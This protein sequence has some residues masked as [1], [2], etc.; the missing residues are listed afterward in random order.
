MR[1]NQ[2]TILGIYHVQEEYIK[3]L[4]KF[5]KKVTII[6]DSGKSRPF[7][8]IVY[9][10]NEF[11]YFAPFSSPEKDENGN[12]TEEYKKY[13]NKNNVPAYERI[14]DLKYG[15]ILINNMIPIPESELIFFKID[16]IQ[17]ENYKN[18]LKDQFIYCDDNK[19]K[20]I[21]KAFKLY[22]LVVKNKQP[23]FANISCKF[24]LLEKKCLEYQGMK[25][26]QEIAEVQ[27]IVAFT[28][29]IINEK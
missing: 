6:K 18:I 17:D 8:G 16:D 20:I 4:R 14:S 13:F 12:I 25:E 2:M 23:H 21:D 7:V 22:K 9:Q 11:K 28:P 5:D 1:H 24:K 29:E 10:I 15:V 27:K 26:I 19:Q 3:Y